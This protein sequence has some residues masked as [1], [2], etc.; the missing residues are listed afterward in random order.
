M[1]RSTDRILTTHAGSLPRPRDLLGLVRSRA[2]GERVDEAAFQARLRQ[3]VGEVVRKQAALGIDVVDD[4]EFGKPSFVTYVRERLGGLTRQEGERQSPWVRSREAI[5]FPEFYKAQAGA[6]NARQALMSCT[7]PIT[8]RGYKEL[9]T[10]LD[11]L[12]AA[13]AGVDVAEVFVPSISPSNIEDWNKNQYYKTPEDYLHAIGEAMRQEYQA[14]VAAGFL[15]QIDDPQLVTHYVVNPTATVEQCRRWAQMH[16]EAL[17]HAIRGIPREKIRYHTCY[18]INMGPRVHDM[19]AKDIIDIVLRINAGAFSFEASNPRHEHE[20]TV[21]ERA[22]IPD[23]AVLIPGVI[24]H[25]TILVEHPELI[26]QRIARYAKI[27]G[28][29][30]VIAGSD[31]GFATFAGS[32]EVHESIVWAKFDALGKGARIASRELWAKQPGRRSAKAAAKPKRA[33]AKKPAKGR[34]T[35]ARTARKV[36]KR[37]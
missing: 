8:Y 24:S 26:A 2:R 28:R 34:K 19:E 7:G 30:N 17:N 21:W 33:P 14:I 12:K 23:G 15:V 18:G 32:D 9:Q 5:S 11:N 10:D 25:S 27:V 3:A 22:K 31:C 13:L 20:W 29:Q 37:R 35:S 36:A 1:Q 16:V 6:V 4:G